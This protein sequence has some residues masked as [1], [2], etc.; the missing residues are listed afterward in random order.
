MVG[1][2]L[3]CK[4]FKAERKVIEQAKE[5]GIREVVLKPFSAMTLVLRIQQ[6]FEKGFAK[7]EDTV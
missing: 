6:I 2:I 1:S 5:A 7:L 4:I 3:V